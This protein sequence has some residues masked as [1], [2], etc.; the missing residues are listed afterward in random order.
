MKKLGLL[1][2]EVSASRIK[3]TLKESNS[4]F[5]IKF[6][7]LSGPEITALRQT[8]LNSKADLFVVKNSVARKAFKESGIE[9]LLPTLEGP[10]GLVFAKDEP[11]TTS[12]TLYDFA[13]EHE[14]LK[15]EGAFL[16]DKFLTQQDIETLAKL[17]SKEV[18]RAKIVGA[19]IS[20]IFGLVFVLNANLRNL[21]SCLEQIKNKKG[22]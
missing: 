4:V 19:L 8:L 11:V 6:S 18:L 13:K 15:L 10:S 16:Q 5:V 9:A 3:N 1:F 17:P 2:K 7:G 22:K 14:K 21:V 12:K 20:P